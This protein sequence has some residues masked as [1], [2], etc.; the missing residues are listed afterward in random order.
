M[1][2]CRVRY[3]RVQKGSLHTGDSKDSVHSQRPGAHHIESCVSSY[4]EAKG[5]VVETEGSVLEG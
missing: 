2:T 5:S 4:P 3:G 1:R